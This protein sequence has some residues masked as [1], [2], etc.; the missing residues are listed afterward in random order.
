[1][2]FPAEGLRSTALATV[3]GM[4][5]LDLRRVA[6]VLSARPPARGPAIDAQLSRLAATFD[7][8]ARRAPAFAARAQGPGG[9][10]RLALDP[11]P[12]AGSGRH[13]AFL[14]RVAAEELL[15]PA[16]VRSRIDSAV[17]VE[18]AE[19]DLATRLRADLDVPSPALPPIHVAGLHAELAAATSRAS[20]LAIASFGRDAASTLAALA[21]G[22]ALGRAALGSAS[23]PAC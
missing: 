11:I 7:H 16:E 15:D 17:A 20:T 8:A 18:S 22:E 2:D 9:H 21:L 4:G 6:G 19:A 12:L 5:G 23:G 10:W 14:D 3:P 13:T 1:M